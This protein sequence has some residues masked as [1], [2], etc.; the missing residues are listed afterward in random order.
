MRRTHGHHFP[1]AAGATFPFS[2]AQDRNP[3]AR[4]PVARRT[5]KAAPSRRLRLHFAHLPA[6]S[7]SCSLLGT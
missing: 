1:Y 5:L 7:C 6:T 2:C 3:L 4:I